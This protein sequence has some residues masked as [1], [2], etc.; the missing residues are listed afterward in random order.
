[1]IR[2]RCDRAVEQVKASAVL[3]TH[4]CSNSRSLTLMFSLSFSSSHSFAEVMHTN[5]TNWSVTSFLET[6]TIIIYNGYLVP[7]MDGFKVSIALLTTCLFSDE[8][9][10]MIVVAI[11]AEM[12]YP[13]CEQFNMTFIHSYCKYTGHDPDKLIQ[14]R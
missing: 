1:M 5:S 4:S 13:Q 11:E 14:R 3:F 10:I 2:N 12:L 8:Q 9:D 6:I 7:L